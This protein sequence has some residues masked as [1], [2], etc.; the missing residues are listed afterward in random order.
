LSAGRAAY[1]GKIN[2]AFTFFSCDLGLHYDEIEDG[3]KA[4]YY[5]NKLG[6]DTENEEE[7]AREVKFK[8]S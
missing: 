1:F 8:L 2:N 7:K 3:S 5:L 6:V 4:E